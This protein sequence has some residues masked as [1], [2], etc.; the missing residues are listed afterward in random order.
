MNWHSIGYMDNITSTAISSHDYY[1]MP[2]LPGFSNPPIWGTE[3]MTNVGLWIRYYRPIWLRELWGDIRRGT[4]RFINFCLRRS[5]V[6][7]C[8]L[9]PWTAAPQAHVL[10]QN[11][12]WPTYRK[13]RDLEAESQHK[14]KV[15]I[16]L[17]LCSSS[18]C[19]ITTCCL[20]C[21]MVVRA[22]NPPKH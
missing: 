1:F 15:N 6:P 4:T 21:H 16:T 7:T 18:F 3:L 8:Q 5:V 10:S 11:W 22:G 20:F 19:P 17:K 2:N 12:Q 14:V 9:R 13:A